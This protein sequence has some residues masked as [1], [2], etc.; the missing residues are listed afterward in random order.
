MIGEY[1]RCK[2]TTQPVDN[3]FQLCKPILGGLKF[4][5]VLNHSCTSTDP[6]LVKARVIASPSSNVGS[7]ADPSGIDNTSI[8][9]RRFASTGSK[10][11]STGTG[12][13]SRSNCSRV[14]SRTRC[15]VLLPKYA[16][17]SAIDT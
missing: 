15:G 2:F 6:R 14:A 17:N 16:K 12:K 4:S 11:V 3:F 7:K 1:L 5:V 10:R 9:Y 8:P 13:R